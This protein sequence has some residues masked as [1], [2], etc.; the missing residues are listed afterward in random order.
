MGFYLIVWVAV[1]GFSTSRYICYIVYFFGK[2]FFLAFCF[3]SLS[4]S[5]AI[6]LNI[7]SVSLS[8]SSSV[9]VLFFV[10]CI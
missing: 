1:V 10:G 9:A 4:S 3:F 2:L 8:S 6:D 7:M 5:N